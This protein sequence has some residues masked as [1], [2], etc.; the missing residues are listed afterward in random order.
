METSKEGVTGSSLQPEPSAPNGITS[1]SDEKNVSTK[2]TSSTSRRK[3]Y[4]MECD[5]QD[6][7]ALARCRLIRLTEVEEP[8]QLA[9][10]ED[11]QGLPISD[12][13]QGETPKQ[14]TPTQCPIPLSVARKAMKMVQKQ[15]GKDEKKLRSDKESC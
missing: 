4:L 1:H 12:E 14:C 6:N 11:V 5:E 3:L 13:S 15:R 8:R 9:E 10:E 7:G 2:N